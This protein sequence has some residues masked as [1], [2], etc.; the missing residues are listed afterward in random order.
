MKSSIH[1]DL[2]DLQKALLVLVRPGITEPAAGFCCPPDPLILEY[3]QFNYSKPITQHRYLRN[4]NFICPIII[5]LN[6][7]KLHY[8]KK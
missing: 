6:S 7:H 3:L 1:F 8:T 4:N 5:S 2:N